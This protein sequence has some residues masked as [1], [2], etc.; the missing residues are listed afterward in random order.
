MKAFDLLQR[1]HV[2]YHFMFAV[3]MSRQINALSFLQV[4]E[5]SAAWALLS[6]L[7]GDSNLHISVFN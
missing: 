2:N 4:F 3:R 5:E 1:V 6:Y 7:C